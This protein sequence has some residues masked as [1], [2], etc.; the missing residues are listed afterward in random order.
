KTTGGGRVSLRGSEVEPSD[1]LKVL[2]DD[3]D[4]AIEEMAPGHVVFTTPVLGEGEAG[5]R[6]VALKVERKGIVV[7]RQNLQ[8][9]TVP[10]IES[11]EPAEAAVGDTVTLKG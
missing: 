10:Q 5:V 4:A 2:V 7:L 3:K 1:T 11:A 8:Y 9:E 6:P